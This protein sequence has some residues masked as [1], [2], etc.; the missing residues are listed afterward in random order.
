[1]TYEDAT[2]ALEKG[3]LTGQQQAQWQ[4]ELMKDV[5]GENPAVFVPT[6][7]AGVDWVLCKIADARARAARVRE[8]MENMARAHEREAEFF[9]WKY[10][11]AL[12]T[13]AR[14]EIEGGHRKS[15]RLPNGVLGYRTKPAGVNV[16][17]PAAA[18]AWAQDNCREA[19]IERLDKKALAETLLATGEV[20][21]FAQIQPAEDVFYIK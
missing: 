8:N 20:L 21:D 11:P 15:V 19:V 16:T 14:G 2:E 5:P 18:L 9:E 12:Q 1:M 4:T 6:D 17:D 7:A 13:W 10:G 3:A